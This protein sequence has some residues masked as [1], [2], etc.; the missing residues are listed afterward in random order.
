MSELTVIYSSLADTKRA[1]LSGPFWGGDRLQPEKWGMW[2]SPIS[3]RL[4]TETNWE[5]KCGC[6]LHLVSI[7][8]PDQQCPWGD[9]FPGSAIWPSSALC[10]TQHRPY[11]SNTELCMGTTHGSIR[12]KITFPI[13]CSRYLRIL[14]SDMMTF[15]QALW[16]VCCLYGVK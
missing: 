14:W 5:K 2:S 16:S 10:Q 11:S 8:S 4:V 7:S 6:V 9:A 1:Q 13:C 15:G 12:F 3:F